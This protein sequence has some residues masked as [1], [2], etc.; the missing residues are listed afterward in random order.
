MSRKNPN[1]G[2]PKM[3]KVETK[4]V[5][6]KVPITHIEQSKKVMR[7]YLG[8]LA[9]PKKT[10]IASGRLSTIKLIK[11]LNEQFEELG[12]KQYEVTKIVRLN[13]SENDVE[14]GASKLLIYY[15]N[16]TISEDLRFMDSGTFK[17]KYNITEL[18]NLLEQ[19]EQLYIKD[20]SGKSKISSFELEFK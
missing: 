17:S 6:F 20:N 9:V 15:E 4:P 14:Q 7:D 16:K 1:A 10:N 2:K 12:I 8:T 19:G 18:Q 5:S 11:W 3:Y 13:T